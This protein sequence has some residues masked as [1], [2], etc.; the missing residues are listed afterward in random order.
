MDAFHERLSPEEQGD[1]AFAYRVAFVPKVVNRASSAD[2]AIEFVK[3]GSDEA[4]K[5]NE[6][7]LKETDKPKFLPMQIVEMMNAEGYPGFTINDHTNLWQS[8][9]A[10]DPAKSFGTQMFGGKQW[11]WY[12]TW[13]NRVRAHCQEHCERY[14]QPRKPPQQAPG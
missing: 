6:V 4:I 10:K 2:Y 8:L 3:P 12:E 11:A 5:I 1:P 7:L 9:K 14:K 13:V